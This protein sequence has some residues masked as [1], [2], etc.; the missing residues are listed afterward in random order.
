[1][2]RWLEAHPWLGAFAVVA[3]IGVVAIGI[4]LATGGDATV[5]ESAFAACEIAPEFV[6]DELIAPRDAAF[7]NC[8][9]ERG[10]DGIWQV[11]GRVDAPNAFGARVRHTYRLRLRYAGDDRWTLRGAVDLTSQ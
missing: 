8:R 11:A 3:G 5:G 10:S 4:V 7:S 1:M 2:N 6:A 9:A